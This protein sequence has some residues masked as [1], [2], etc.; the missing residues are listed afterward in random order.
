MK[1]FIAYFDYLGFKEFILNND[2]DFQKQIMG[3]NFRDIEMAIGQDKFIEAPHGFQADLSESRIHCIN[4]S[5]SVIF[6]TESD[7]EADLIELLEVAHRFNWHSIGYTFPVRGALVYDELVA[8]PYKEEN[9]AGGTYNVNSVFG[10]G[11]VRAYSKADS[12]HWAGTVVAQSV[13][14]KI[15]EMGI[16]SEQFLS[17]YAKRYHVPYR[18]EIA[19]EPEF[20][21]NL[22][23]PGSL[24]KETFSQMSKD[25]KDNFAD[26]NKSVDHPGVQEKLTNTIAFLGSYLPQ[27]VDGPSGRKEDDRG[28]DCERTAERDKQEAYLKKFPNTKANQSEWSVRE[29][30]LERAWLNRDFE[31]NKY[32]QRAAYFWGFIVLLIGGYLTIKNAKPG[33]GLL[34]S[35]WEFELYF[36][37]LGIVF[38]LAWYLV[39][40]GSKRWQENW[41]GHI[42]MLE[43]E[44]T[45]PLYKT[46][47]H[48]GTFHSVSGINKILSITIL[49]VW[50][51]L[52][53]TFF[54]GHEEY[55]IL[56]FDSE[57]AWSVNIPI[58]IT[59]VLCVALIRTKKNASRQKKGY[60]FQRPGRGGS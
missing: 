34:E 58:A 2:L 55:S 19:H 14:D 44:I 15:K 9:S 16:D 18:N 57:I 26:L 28:G 38:S 27:L 40:Q 56:D 39:N 46:L 59:A 23:K 4:F 1:R 54:L 12:Q 8:V 30:A 22:I 10:K 21:L 35:P 25:I 41:E 45:G 32:W 29:R 17:H 24:N 51:G 42:D 3:N 31:I 13:I 7:D 47:Y 6:Y 52:F 37:L 50:F 36:I 20:V 5:D 53:I 43:D 11:L 33:S 49:L 60:F 48:S